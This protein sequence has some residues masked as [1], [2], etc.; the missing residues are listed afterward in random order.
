MA[1]TSRLPYP[2][3]EQQTL[4]MDVS[5]SLTIQL[6]KLKFS[7]LG[8]DRSSGKQTTESPTLIQQHRCSSTAGP[9]PKSVPHTTVTQETSHK[10]PLGSATPCVCA[11]AGLCPQSCLLPPGELR[12]E[13]HAGALP[14]HAPRHQTSENISQNRPC[15][16]FLAAK[17]LPSCLPSWALPAS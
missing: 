8:S 12:H 15:G 4:Q 1:F 6:R 9:R 7:C 17:H 2:F 10:S 11:G 5:V 3:H 16:T 14:A 13:N